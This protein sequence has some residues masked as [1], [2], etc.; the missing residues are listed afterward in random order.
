M[1]PELAAEAE[2]TA[3][4]GLEPAVDA[5][6]KAGRPASVR[7]ARMMPMR[8]TIRGMPAVSIEQAKLLPTFDEPSGAEDLPSMIELSPRPPAAA[9]SASAPPPGTTLPDASDRAQGTA[10]PARRPQAIAAWAKAT[11]ERA[12]AD[13]RDRRHARA[14][15]KGPFPVAFAEE[16]MQSAVTTEAVLE[17]LFDFAQQ[18]FEYTALFVVHGDVAEGRDASGRGADRD[19]VAA[20]GL[21]LD[22]PSVLATARTRR[23]PILAQFASDG[24]D[25]ELLRDLGRAPATEGAP[26]SPTAPP[27]RAPAVVIPIVVRGRAVALLFGDDAPAPVELVAI[28]DVIAFAALSGASIE[29]IILRK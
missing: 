9:K 3:A 19:R 28:G 4:P 11:D 12:R 22:L 26:A 17:V 18:F 5:A 10:E 21:P 24:M 15:R 13:A 8:P 14:R 1:E 16:E 20:I 25:A 2:A 27:R 6:A 29:R 7:P 23:V